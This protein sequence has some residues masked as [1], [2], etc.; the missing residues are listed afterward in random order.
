[1]GKSIVLDDLLFKVNSADIDERSMNLLNQLVDFMNQNPKIRIEIGGH[2][3]SD[4]S[5]SFN[6]QLSESRAKSA[7]KYLEGRGIA[8]GRL[9][10]KGYGKSNPIVA[11]DSAEN[12][13]KNRR[14]EMKVID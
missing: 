11:N 4:G 9:V 6:Q 10:A 14:V 8:S 12:K 5:D 13:A 7:V 2:T 1:V 3:D